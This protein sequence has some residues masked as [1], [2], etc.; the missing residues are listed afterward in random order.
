MTPIP[1]REQLFRH[2]TAMSAEFSDA[3]FVGDRSELRRCWDKVAPKAAA[4]PGTQF[5]FRTKSL[6]ELLSDMS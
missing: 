6:R 1:F 4:I 3:H 2:S 5:L